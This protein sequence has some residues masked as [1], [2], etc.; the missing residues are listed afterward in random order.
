MSNT[1]QAAELAIVIPAY[2]EATRLPRTLE[3]LAKQIKSGE[4]N[5]VKISQVI[6]VDDGSRDQ[7]VEVVKKYE[8][9]LPQL[10]VLKSDKNYG[11]GH[12]VRTGLL[13][14]EAPWLLVADA[15]MAT[16]WEEVLKLVEECQAQQADIAIG[17]RDLKESEIVIRQSWV[18][19]H[20]GKTFNLMVRS[21]TQLPFKDTQCGFKLMKKNA[22]AAFLKKLTVDRFA[23]DV[24]F[25]MLA[26]S[27]GLKI[28]EVAVRWSHQEESRVH[29]V[30]DGI[31]MAYTISKLRLSHWLQLRKYN[32]KSSSHK[33][34]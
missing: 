20:M 1:S 9:S 11:K 3:V 32:L 12:A 16:P 30:K 15:D 34:P 7:T 5:S 21:I 14:A 29:P 27:H 26:Q 17:S 13:Y 33:A 31:N 2:N 4:L 19:E 25:L 24:E 8:A 28:V 6:V 22:V 23:W 18:R 10:L